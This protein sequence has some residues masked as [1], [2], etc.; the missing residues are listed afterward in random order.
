MVSELKP[1]RILCIDRGELRLFTEVIDTLT[2][3]GCYWVRPLA[4]ARAVV[5]NYELELLFDLREAPQLILPID[6]F[7]PAFDTEVLPLISQLFALNS[8]PEL[9]I[10]AR[11]SLHE[12]INSLYAA[13]SP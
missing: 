6:L 8:D 12:F 1:D 11:R 3:R 4:I 13:T 9:E 7:R 10:R 5:D 2:E